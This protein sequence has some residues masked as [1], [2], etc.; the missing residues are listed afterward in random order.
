MPVCEKRDISDF[1]LGI[2]VRLSKYAILIEAILKS[3]KDKKD[4]ENLTQA[5]LMAKDVVQ[6]VDEKVAAYEKLVDIQTKLDSRAVVYKNKKFKVSEE[7]LR[8]VG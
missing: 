3:T 1:I 2:T 6:H 5:L 8:C 7:S 4:R